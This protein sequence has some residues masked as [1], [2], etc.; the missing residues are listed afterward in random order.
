MTIDPISAIYMINHGDP[1]AEARFREEYYNEPKP[2]APVSNRTS[3][4]ARNETLIRAR[5]TIRIGRFIRLV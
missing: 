5:N 2:E 3:I 4:S 1:S